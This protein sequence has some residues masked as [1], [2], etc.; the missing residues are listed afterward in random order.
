MPYVDGYLLPVP[1]KNVKA[2][3]AM[4]RKAGKIWMEY[5]ALQYRECVSDDIDVKGVAPFSR[6]MKLKP[7]EKLVFSWIVYKSR[8]QRDRINAKVIADPRLKCDK[9]KMPFDPKR[10]MFGGFNV[11][12]N[13]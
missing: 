11:L 3:R 10:M 6:T 5:G 13:L 12:V 8:A 4:S 9:S 7:G 2:Y 1:A